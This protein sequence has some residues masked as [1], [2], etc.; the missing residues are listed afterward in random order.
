MENKNFY[1]LDI[2]L[3]LLVEKLGFARVVSGSSE[4]NTRC[5][6]PGCDLQQNRKH[7]HLYISLNQSS[8]PTFFCQR[9][10][11][12]GLIFKL[13]S[14][15]DIDRTLVINK[16]SDCFN[17]KSFI[18]KNTSNLNSETIHEVKIEKADISRYEHKIAYLKKRLGKEIDVDVIPN[19]VLD[20]HS[21]LDLN[22]VKCSRE[23]E[24]ILNY[25][26]DQFIGFVSSRGTKLILRNVDESTDF[27]YH[28]I[29]LVEYPSI[30]K[31]FYGVSTNQ[32]YAKVNTIVLCEGIFDLLVAINSPKLDDIKRKSCY[33]ACA[34]GAYYKK[35]IPSVLDYLKLPLSDVIILSDS[36]KSESDKIYR[37]LNYL[38]L[39]NNLA[40]YYNEKS[41][42]FGEGVSRPVRGSIR[43]FR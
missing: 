11:E 17:T 29:A 14:I 2:F 5:P 12:S 39:I 6:F 18:K 10:N 20:I 42:D 7:G 31:D 43:T 33:W 3:K 21:F 26:E 41:K 15:L 28:K 19:L 1:N 9:C 23:D 25:L 24:S 32:T 36:D 27:R 13:L 40:I 4:I 34:L 37:D 22:K 16:D 35:L 30:F 8:G 38:A